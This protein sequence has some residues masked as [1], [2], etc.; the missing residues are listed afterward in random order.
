M[1]LCSVIDEGGAMNV[2]G[3]PRPATPAKPGY[4]VRALERALDILGAFSLGRPELSLTE[5]AARTC[6]SKSTALRLLAVLDER[7]FVERSPETDRYRV[8]LRLFEVGSVYIQTVAI[9][10]V[11]RP[12]LGRLAQRC[13]QT[14]NLGVL[15]YDEVVHLA[16]LAP[17][18]PI[19]FYAHVG[20]REKA[21]ATGLGKVLLAELDDDELADLVRRRALEPRTRRTIVSLDDLRQHLALVREQGFAIDDEESAVGLRCVAAAVR[22]H[23]NRAVAAVSV[24]GPTFEVRDELLPDYV[25]AV[26]G[27][28]HEISDRLGNRVQS[29][30]S[31]EDADAGLEYRGVVVG[32]R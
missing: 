23:Q 1:K 25:E 14:A 2:R 5:I 21:H 6:L 4:Q 7:G 15:S 16:V 17:D 9:D 10:A 22:D 31:V 12:I 13:N 26:V 18:R 11:A 32:A 19:R 29:S 24:S 20:Q 27:A 8:G 28:A 30:A 3:L